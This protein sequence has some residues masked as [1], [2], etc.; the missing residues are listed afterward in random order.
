MSRS[1]YFQLVSLYKARIAVH[2]GRCSITEDDLPI[3]ERAVALVRSGRVRSSEEAFSPTTPLG[4][5]G[6]GGA[7]G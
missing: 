7:G 3:L 2:N 6:V 1:K 4:T 5:R